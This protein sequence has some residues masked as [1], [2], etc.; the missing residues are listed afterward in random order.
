MSPG[1]TRQKEPGPSVLLVDSDP[2]FLVETSKLV[3]EEGHQAWGAEDLLAAAN[4]LADHEPDL[5]L[6]EL[7]LLETDG[8]DPF[9]DLQSRAPAAPTILTAP[10]PPDERFR[11]L[12]RS[13]EIFGY[14]DKDHGPGT[15]RL[16][17]NAALTSVRHLAMLRHTRQGMRKVL[18]AVPALHSIQSLDEV[19][20]AILERLTGL[21]GGERA[22]VAARISDPVGKPPIEGFTLSPQTTD[23]YVIGA[24]NSGAYP[25]GANVDKLK[26][27]PAHLL[28]RAVEERTE[29]IDDR[30]GVLP[31]A[32]AEHVLGLAYA[33]RPGPCGRDLELLRIFASQAAAAIRNAAL[34]ELAT[35]DATTR[36]FQKAFTLDR[37]RGMLNLAWRK[38]FPV[39]VLMIDIDRFKALNDR[40]GHV[41]GDRALRHLGALLKS[42][43]RDS[44]V[45]GRFGGDE[46][47][48]ILIDA[49]HEGADIVADRLSEV[50]R[51]GRGP[52]PE[53][54]PPLEA[55]MGLVTLEPGE[56]SAIELGFP[57]FP[58]AAERLV[59]EA[60][61][62]MY[63]ARREEKVMHAGPT[64]TWADFT[65]G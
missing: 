36:V 17:L 57:D 14:Y 50:L 18:E 20:A 49:N 9:G 7:A 5:M 24:A 25:A 60:D 53:G 64:L 31:L 2:R 3:A 41:V 4:F 43:V 15:L 55:S 62:A 34:Y 42:N 1:K 38:A 54:V 51:A 48:V 23:D 8:A 6:V 30:H 56:A 21:M 22:F 65:R 44:D 40:Y 35:V 39:T 27:I 12:C 33:S 26:S 28:S 61:A 10:G 29:I 63:T 45:V 37:L 46:F 32:L 11:A 19:Q 47:L 52:R 58:A 16:L 13:H 59:A